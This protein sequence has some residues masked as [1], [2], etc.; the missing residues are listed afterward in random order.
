MHAKVLSVVA[1][2]GLALGLLAAPAFAQD[3]PNQGNPDLVLT[4]DN[5]EV[6]CDDPMPLPKVEGDLGSTIEFE[7]QSPIDKVTVKSGSKAEFVSA[8]FSPTGPPYT[9]T[10]TL[11]QDV[12][13]YVIWVCVETP[14]T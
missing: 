5:P 10:I 14:T 12:S 9:G 4:V 1:G 13:N 6:S 3:D 2:G 8:D 11:T 7:A